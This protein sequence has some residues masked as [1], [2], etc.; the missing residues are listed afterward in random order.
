VWLRVLEV[1]V[2]AMAAVFLV[3]LLLRWRTTRRDLV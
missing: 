1:A 2:G 3:G